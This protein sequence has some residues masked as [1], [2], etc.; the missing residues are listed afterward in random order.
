MLKLWR[1]NDDGGAGADAPQCK[2]EDVTTVQGYTAL[3]HCSVDL[4]G[5]CGYLPNT[6]RYSRVGSENSNGRSTRIEIVLR[7]AL[8]TVT[9]DPR[10][11]YADS[12]F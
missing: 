8:P 12:T 3:N 9:F 10:L 4:F 11:D 2:A 7:I 1:A 5:T 6:Y